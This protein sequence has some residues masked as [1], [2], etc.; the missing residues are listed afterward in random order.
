MTPTEMPTLRAADWETERSLW[1][2]LRAG[3]LSGFKFRRQHPV[4]PFFADFFCVEVGLVVEVDGPSHI[5]REARD[6]QRDR[7]LVTC[8][9]TVVHV[10]NDEVLTDPSVR[11]RVSED[12]F[13]HHPS[14][15]KPRKGEGT[16]VRVKGL[17]PAVRGTQT[18][19]ASG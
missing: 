17:R 16:G 9:F 15:R 10:T 19:D 11:S 13:R 3:R 6:L 4:G 5:G 12:T 8:G 14:P 1:D 18:D 7:W 2:L